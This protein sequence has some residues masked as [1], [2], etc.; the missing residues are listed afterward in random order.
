MEKLY[1]GVDILE[2][3]ESAHN[4][5]DYI[6]RLVRESAESKDL[7]DFGAGDWDILQTPADGR[8]SC[9]VHRAGSATEA[10]TGGSRVSTHWG[11]LSRSRTIQRHAFLP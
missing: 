5:N 9:H 2:A 11:I 4:Y 8:V 7:I 10:K 3:L 1:S 6:T